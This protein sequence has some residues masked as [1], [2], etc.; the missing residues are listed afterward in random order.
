MQKNSL[1]VVKFDI[2]KNQFLAVGDEHVI[3]IWDMDK[4]E[5]LTTID[6]DGGLLVSYLVSDFNFTLTVIM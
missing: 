1:A 6:A 5:L 2:M 4:V 3:K